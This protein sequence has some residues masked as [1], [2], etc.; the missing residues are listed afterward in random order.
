[1][2]TEVATGA[3]ETTRV[4]VVLAVY[5]GLVPVIVTVD[6]EA[7]ALTA[8][9][10]ITKSWF[11]PSPLND[12]VTPD[13]RPVADKAMLPVAVNPPKVLIYTAF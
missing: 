2:L 6:V 11:D 8:A 12:A 13:G 9:V 10:K 5:V 7:G 3:V 1:M 4:I